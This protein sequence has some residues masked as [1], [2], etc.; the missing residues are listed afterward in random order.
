MFNVLVQCTCTTDIY[1]SSLAYAPIFVLANSPNGINKSNIFQSRS[2]TGRTEKER[3]KEE[4]L[5]ARRSMKKNQLR[6]EK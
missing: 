2:R 3:E 1:V 5:N 4:K 6:I